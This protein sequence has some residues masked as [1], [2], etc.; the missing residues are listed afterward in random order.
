MPVTRGHHGTCVPCMAWRDRNRVASGANAIT[1]ARY[2]ET[3]PG[4]IMA[5]DTLQNAKRRLRA[6]GLTD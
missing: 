1:R 5:T 4:A 3:H 6:Y 2:R